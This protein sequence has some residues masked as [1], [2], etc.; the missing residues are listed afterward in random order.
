MVL[1]VSWSFG[2]AMATGPSILFDPVTGEVISND[3]AGEPWYPASLTKLMTAYLVFQKLKS[4]QLTLDRTVTVSEIAHA[5]PPSKIGLPAGKTVTIDFAL[6]SLL[7]YSANDM[8]FVLAEA[9]GGTWQNFV[10]A[11]NLTA[12]SMGMTATHYVNPNGLFEPRQITTARDMALLT[13]AILRDFPEFAHYFSQPFVAVGK[14]KLSNRNSLI[15]QWAEADGMKTG[16]V[17]NSG[18]NLVASAT[19]AG[20][21]LVAVVLGAQSGKARVDLAQMLLTD[22][23]SR[24]PE[25]TKPRIAQLANEQFGA[26]VPADMTA[27]VCR[28]KPLVTVTSARDLTGWGISLGKY[29]T[30]QKADMALRGR[31]LSPSAID[32]AGEVGVIKV[33]GEDT[34]A[35]VIWNVDQTRSLAMCARYRTEKAYCD[36]MTPETF[37]QIAA[38]TPKPAS[39][40]EKPEA[41]GSDAGKTKPKKKKKR[42]KK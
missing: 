19:R 35:A 30:A 7:V 24:A 39:R 3:R 5:Q 11:M 21:K 33:P 27:S 14:R 1:L 9:A 16:F 6:Q 32:A 8:A 17:C 26:I 31:L 23:F 42:K 2:Q 29:E 40:A 20:R 15:R 10:A 4:G 25:A 18:F 12:K 28:K 37:A 38:L 36:V 34:F 13:S 22:G 41:Q